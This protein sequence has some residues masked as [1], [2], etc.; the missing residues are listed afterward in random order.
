MVREIIYVLTIAVAWVLGCIF[1]VGGF[2]A[3]LSGDIAQARLELA[4]ANCCLFYLWLGKNCEKFLKG[5]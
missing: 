3:L 2:W 1:V 5:R 4:L